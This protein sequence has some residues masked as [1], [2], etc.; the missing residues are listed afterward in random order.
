MYALEQDLIDRFTE[1]EVN[2]LQGMHD[3][4]KTSVQKALSDATAYINSYLSA[5]EYKLPVP[6]SEYLTLVC[7]NVARYYLYKG[8]AEGE[9]RKRYEE[10]EQ[11]LKDVANGKANVPFAEPLTPQ[12]QKDLPKRAAAVGKAYKG[13]VFSDEMFSKMPKI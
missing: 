7:C 2:H 12:Q 5:R 3:D 4:P 6:R 9:V 1:H 10:A 8:D 13:N 11:W